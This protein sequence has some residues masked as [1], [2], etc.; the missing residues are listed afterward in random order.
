MKRRHVVV[1]AAAVVSTA[2]AGCADDE[3]DDPDEDLGTPDPDAV[4][5]DETNGP[6][7]PEPTPA[8]RAVREYLEAV[9]EGDSETAN[10]RY[11]DTDPY[12]E[13]M[14][15]TPGAEVLALTEW[16]RV[17]AI[18]ASVE[19]SEEEAGSLIEDLEADRAEIADGDPAIDALTY[20]FAAITSDDDEGERQY[21][22][23]TVEVDDEWLV[24]E[25]RPL[26][27]L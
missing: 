19:V 22:M 5:D 25:Q 9:G 12:D 8:T 2:L 23:V 10:A 11:Y 16:D 14:L 6:E 27:G 18:T 3:S 1:G 26:T 20:V 21:V 13:E 15:S 24:Y 7:P 4:P 17:D